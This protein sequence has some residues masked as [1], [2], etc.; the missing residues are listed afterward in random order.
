[1]KVELQMQANLADG[2]R[3]ETFDGAPYAIFPAVLAVEGVLNNALVLA[4]EMQA[5]VE[6]WNGRPIPIHHPEVM[7]EPISAN[8]PEVIERTIGQI[9]NARVDGNKL[10]GELWINETK[11]DRLGYSQL[12]SAMLEG[13]V[14]ELSTGYLAQAE[15]VPGEFNGIPYA[16]IHRKMQPDHVALLPGDIG[17]CSIADGC[18]VPRINKLGFVGMKINEQARAALKAL[19]TALGLNSKCECQEVTMTKQEA[20]KLAKKLCGEGADPKLVENTASRLVANKAITAEQLEM[21][22][23]MD[24]DQLAMAGAL[25]GA[26]GQPAAAEEE[27][28][29]EAPASDPPANADAAA[30]QQQQNSSGKETYTKA[31]VDAMI[32]N[33]I[34]EQSRRATVTAKLLANKQCPFDEKE[35]QAMKVEH[36]EKLEESIRPADYRGVGGFGTEQEASDGDAPLQI[37]RGVLSKKADKDAKAE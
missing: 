22:Q 11:A 12:I 26:L 28:E 37:N 32:A 10:K 33:G 9:F 30:Q 17:A 1:M 2:V 14:I 16:A 18:G 6:S 36:L 23:K 13:E 29:E 34:K 21:L 5:V 4:S 25:I 8:T 19:Q 31:E 35:M 15:E 27:E 24:G 20:I 7:G 3:R